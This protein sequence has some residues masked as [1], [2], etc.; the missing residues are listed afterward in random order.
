MRMSRS[1]DTQQFIRLRELF[2]RITRIEPAQRDTVIRAECADSPELEHELRML[3][4]AHDREQGH[5]G[6]TRARILDEGHQW[7][8]SAALPGERVGPWR[9]REVIG[10]GG[11]AVVYRAERADGVV[12]QEVAVKVLQRLHLDEAGVRRFAQE[13][14]IVAQLAHPGIA[15]LFDAGTTRDGSPYYAME[16]IDGEPIVAWCERRKASIAERLDLF[17]DVCDAVR[18]AHANLVLHRD[19][20]PANVLVD[21]NGAA[22][23]IDFGIAKPLNA[24]DATQAGLQLFSPSNAAPEQVRGE[25]CGVACDVYQL[26]TL[27][28]ELL[29]AET[30]LGDITRSSTAIEAAILH[31]VPSRP[32]EVMARKGDAAAARA[33]RGDLDTIVL[34]ALRKEP[35]QRYASVEQLADEIARHRRLEPI[36]ARG[37]ERRYRAMKFV[38]RN[39]SAL[40]AGTAIMVL[41]ITVVVVQLVQS[42][43]LERERDA[44]HVE[45]NRAQAA[46]AFLVDLFQ[47]AHPDHALARELSA[48]DLLKHGRDRIARELADQPELR[49]PLV[50][51]LAIVHATLGDQSSALQLVQE[52]DRALAAGAVLDDRALIAYRI[53]SGRVRRDAGDFAGAERAARAALEIHARLRDAPGVRWEARALLLEVEAPH[54]DRSTSATS[55]SELEADPA[56]DPRVLARA[57]LEVAAALERVEAYEPAEALLRQALVAFESQENLESRDAAEARTAARRALGHVLVAIGRGAEGLPMLEEALE[58]EIELWGPDALTVAR[59]RIQIGGALAR[60]RRF[61]EAEALLLHAEQTLRT[62][63]A[64]PRR[65]MLFASTTVGEVYLAMGRFEDAERRF[66]E[67]LEIAAALPGQRGSDTLAIGYGL[68]SALAQQRRW[69]DALHVLAQYESRV[70]WTE[71]LEA[72]WAVTCAG[73]LHALGRNAEA[74]TLLDRAQP[75]IDGNPARLAPERERSAALRRVLRGT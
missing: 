51:T 9:L 27:L 58:R 22:K 16:L 5:T 10:R 45:R 48:A 20:K 65:D 11:M 52:A 74:T 15:R 23:L 31:R 8:S 57:K 42:Q 3:L 44:A 68:G 64:F 70:S 73:A 26:G 56:C 33:L 29:T 54:P 53:Q 6:G 25:R 19:I 71:P 66:R 72:R 4:D 41:A 38:R 63:G 40:A 34:R 28:Y 18:F 2:D 43:R 61:D 60:L 7:G 13:R 12:T 17:L 69:S 62:M 47:G 75:L 50:G 67:A 59:A 37:G 30:A 49:I 35:Q 14:D 46:S 39:G 32:S 36:A 55:V 21:G 1:P 24:L